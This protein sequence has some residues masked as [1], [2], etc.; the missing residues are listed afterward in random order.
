M[1]APF[2]STIVIGAV[3]IGYPMFGEVPGRLTASGSLIII[4]TGLY[5]VRLEET[6]ATA[7]CDPRAS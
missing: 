5:A 3:I 6:P 1:S 4:A 7:L 2:R